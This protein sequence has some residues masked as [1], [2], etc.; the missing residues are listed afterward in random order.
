ML[1]VLRLLRLSQQSSFSLSQLSTYIWSRAGRLRVASL[2]FIFMTNS[3]STKFKD[4]KVQS[5]EPVAVRV[6]FAKN[7]S[8]DPPPQPK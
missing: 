4:M 5:E 7:V 8:A 6:E 2:I 3:P 1:Q